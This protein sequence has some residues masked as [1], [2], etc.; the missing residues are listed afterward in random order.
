V[1]Q[2][3][4]ALR[5]ES[6]TTSNQQYVLKRYI[7]EGE[8]ESLKTFRAFTQDARYSTSE[9]AK[10]FF[11]GNGN[12]GVTNEYLCEAFCS[13]EALALIR[14]HQHSRVFLIKENEPDC[15]GIHEE[16]LAHFNMLFVSIKVT[17]IQT[18]ATYIITPIDDVVSKKL[19]EKVNDTKDS[20]YFSRSA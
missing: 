20:L 2:K 9:N 7:S 4:Q 11:Y 19:I 3:I 18:G 15:V 5:Q 10:W 13:P 12:P 14:D 6:V 8:F 1:I 16:V 17:K